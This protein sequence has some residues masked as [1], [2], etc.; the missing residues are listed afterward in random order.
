MLPGMLRA[1]ATD[2][3]RSPLLDELHLHLHPERDEKIPHEHRHL[4]LPGVRSAGVPLRVDAGDP[5]QFLEQ[6]DNA[7]HGRQKLAVSGE[8]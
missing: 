5:N 6:F 8:Q 4:P 1:Q 7:G 3:V 2:H